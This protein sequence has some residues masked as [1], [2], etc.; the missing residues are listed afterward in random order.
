MYKIKTSIAGLVLAAAALALAGCTS[1][2]SV[3][4]APDYPA[5]KNMK[6]LNEAATLVV[7]VVVGESSEDV[8][9]P[10]YEGTDPKSNPLAGTKEKPNPNEGAVPITVFDATVNTVYSAPAVPGDIIQIKQLGGTIDGTEYTV[11]GTMP[12]V[13]GDTVILFLVTYPDTAASILG[14]DVGYFIPQDDGYASVG[15][16]NLTI[17]AAELRTL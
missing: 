10:N 6:A 4:L 2:T 15:S 12:L 17:T 9:T 14:G 7:E 1:N 3:A 5:Y 8:L 11:D 13:K 16:D